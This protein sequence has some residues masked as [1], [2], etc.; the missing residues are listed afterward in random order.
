MSNPASQ[1]PFRTL[2]CVLLAWIAIGTHTAWHHPQQ[3]S[4]HWKLLFRLRSNP[5]ARPSSIPHLCHLHHHPSVPCCQPEIRNAR[6]P[7]L[8]SPSH[9][10][11]ISTFAPH[12]PLINF[13]T[14]PISTT[15]KLSRDKWVDVPSALMPPQAGTWQQAMS[16][17]T[18]DLPRHADA[19]T[20]GG[21]YAFPDPNGFATSPLAKVV[22]DLT[23]WLCIRPG[24]CA[25]LM[26]P[27]IVDLPIAPLQVWRSMLHI[28]VAPSHLHR[29]PS[30]PPASGV[31][32]KSLNARRDAQRLFGP[33]FTRLTTMVMEVV[34]HEHVLP[35]VDG[36]AVGLTEN[37]IHKI[38]WELFEHNWR[39]ELL[40]LDRVAAKEQWIGRIAAIDR[41]HLVEKVFWTS[42]KLVVWNDPF[43]TEDI[44]IVDV[45]PAIRYPSL[46]HLQH[47][48]QDWCD[49]PQFLQNNNFQ[50]PISDPQSLIYAK[51]EQVILHFYCKS[52][53][54]FFGRPPPVPHRI[55]LHARS[56]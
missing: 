30:L 42:E 29:D 55:P 27:T 34:W 19:S 37:M 15:I 8:V 28:G 56:T 14:D 31:S 35:V 53:F 38:L 2:R 47:L 25:Q 23:A 7:L 1:G 54:R 13:A 41:Q 24:R 22:C 5:P 9:V 51:L 10:C 12:V 26:D 17:V 16:L 44:K 46:M 32:T 40:R 6:D 4:P 52:Y 45:D 20:D 43:P 36:A 49:C 39:F 50:V 33:L 21:G 3:M 48:M 18:R 11:S